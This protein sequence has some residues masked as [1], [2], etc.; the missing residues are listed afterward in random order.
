MDTP[1]RLEQQLA[2]DISRV[3]L[4]MC[5]FK[6]RK[7]CISEMPRKRWQ[8]KG[9]YLNNALHVLGGRL[10]EIDGR[11]IWDGLP[12]A[13]D[14]QVQGDAPLLPQILHPH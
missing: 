7:S 10:H 12:L 2:F 14:H 3:T 6:Q 11:H 1:E 5:M 4:A 13:I 8:V 9:K